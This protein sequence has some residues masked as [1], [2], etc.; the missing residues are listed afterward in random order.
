MRT[1]SGLPDSGGQYESPVPMSSHLSGIVYRRSDDTGGV[2]NEHWPPAD[3]LKVGPSIHSFL[4]TRCMTG[5]LLTEGSE[6]AR[7][8]PV[9]ADWVSSH[10]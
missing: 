10:D 7:R 5:R 8:G 1:L 2:F 9:T 3:C 6:P 4:V